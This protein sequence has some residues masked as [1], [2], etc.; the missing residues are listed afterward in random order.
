LVEVHIRR[1]SRERLSSFFATGHADWADEGTDIVCA[2]V[3][4]LLQAAWLGLSEVSGLVVDG[5][6][7]SGELS[8]AWPA[9]ARDDAGV[10]AIVETVARSIERLA[11]QYPDHISILNQRTHDDG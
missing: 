3:G 10:R 6:K 2:A 9:E 11:K 5:S 7:K 4:T 1:D 8:L